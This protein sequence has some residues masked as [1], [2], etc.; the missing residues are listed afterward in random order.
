MAISF[1]NVATNQNLTESTSF[2]FTKPTNAAT[3]DL[4]IG[5][6]A[7]GRTTASNS[8]YA[9]TGWTELE[10][11]YDATGINVQMAVFTRVV[12][13][14]DPASWTGSSSVSLEYQS[15]VWCLRGA[16]S[17]LLA[18]E[19]AV[20][21]GTANSTYTS[22]TV[23]NTDSGAW[24]LGAV[25]WTDSAGSASSTV[26]GNTER[27]DTGILNVTGLDEMM[28]AACD[29]NGAIA[30]GNTS[31]TWTPAT[32]GQEDGITWIGLVAPTAG[33]ATNA[34]SGAGAATATSNAPKAGV[35]AKAQVIG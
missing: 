25:V 14:G 4:L 23:N 1:I 22:A 16:D 24:R 20:T 10:D 27:L 5:V 17:T 29:S 2:T 31:I 11:V 19:T 9:C 3:G 35:G 7:N 8:D 30:T 18:S 6:V 21:N 34:P 33:S 26:S 28:M 13:A 32:S 15:I 12:Q